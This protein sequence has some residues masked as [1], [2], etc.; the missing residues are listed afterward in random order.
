MISRR[1]QYLIRRGSLVTERA[2]WLNQWRE[3]SNYIMPRTGRFLVTDRNKGDKRYNSIID[4]TGTR[5][6]RVLAAGL[7]AGMTSPA[8]PWFRLSTTD[9]GLMKYGPVKSWLSNVTEIMRV[10]FSRSN[11]YNSLHT[12]YEELGLYGTGVSIV[13]PDFQDVLRHYPSTCGEYMIS[14]D[15]RNQISTLYREYD[16]TVAMMVQAFG[17][18]NCSGAVRNMWDTGK[19]LDAWVTVLHVIEPRADRER[20]TSKL[21]QAFGRNM[22]Y[23]SCYLEPNAAEMVSG[24]SEKF[25]KESGFKRF[26]ALAARWHATGGDIY[27]NSP[28]MESLG[29]IKQ[30][31]HGQLRKGQAIDY[32]VKP[33]LQIP[34]ALKNMP[35]ATLPGGSA[36]VDQTSAGGGIRSMFDVQLDISAQMEDIRDIRQRIKENFYVDLFLMLAQSDDGGV[37]P[38]SAREVAERHEEKLLMLGPVLERLHNEL[39]KPKIDLTFDRMIETG[40]VPEPPQEMQGQELN[41]EF[42]SMLAQAQRAIGVQGVDRLVMTVGNIAMLQKNAGQMPDVLDKLDFDDI[43]DGYGDML[44]VDPEY[45]VANDKVAIIRQTRAAQQAA[46]AKAQQIAAAANTAKTLSQAKTGPTDQ[47]ALTDVISQFSGYT[48]PGQA[49]AA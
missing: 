28:G 32:K 10:I 33:P 25:L 48:G 1:E 26:P 5:S 2:T 34:T 9:V 4:S 11:T 21:G 23:A 31:Q 45:I 24:G 8:R 46:A 17:R 14:V 41:V 47:N 40:I 49:V 12:L 35:L 20:D 39:L 30:L 37:Q 19:N 3:L 15:A 27:G 13:M 22:P 18:E 7:M 44:G 16:M 29:D 6:L 36:F 42:V 38:V 43:V